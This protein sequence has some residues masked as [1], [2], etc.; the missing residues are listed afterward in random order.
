M[1]AAVELGE[2]YGERQILCSSLIG[3]KPNAHE[4]AILMN[5]DEGVRSLF[6]LELPHHWQTVNVVSCFQANFGLGGHGTD[7]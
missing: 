7:H 5:C 4:A 6:D 2:E 3:D 1:A